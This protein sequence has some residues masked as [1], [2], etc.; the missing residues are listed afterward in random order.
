MFNV[1]IFIIF[2]VLF[3]LVIDMNKKHSRCNESNSEDFDGNSS[4]QYK[5]RGHFKERFDVLLSRIDWLAKNAENK[6]LYTTAYIIAY[7]IMLAVV[8]ILYACS[9]YIVSVWELILILA[10]S[11]IATFSIMN[12]FNFHTEKYTNYYIRKNLNYI[13][14]QLNIE[15]FDPPNPN[16]ESIIPHRTIVQDVLS[17]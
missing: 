14:R 1:F 7:V 9:S 12:L 5:G 16:K 8:I 10:S 4:Y 6:S 17:K 2:T 13:S 3:F 11:F 15:L